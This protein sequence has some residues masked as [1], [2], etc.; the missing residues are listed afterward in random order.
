MCFYTF[1][2]MVSCHKLNQS[3]LIA[4][5]LQSTAAALLFGSHCTVAED[6]SC[7]PSEV[8]YGNSYCEYR[9][10]GSAYVTSPV[11]YY[12]IANNCND[13]DYELTGFT[14]PVGSADDCVQ[15]CNGFS[16]YGVNLAGFRYSCDG[17]CFW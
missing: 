14:E 8:A 15:Q 5:K 12:T 10:D 1:D 7:L 4:M 2:M 3:K 13:G 16:R 6:T 17:T 9:E 11:T